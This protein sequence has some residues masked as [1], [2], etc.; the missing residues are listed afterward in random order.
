[1]FPGFFHLGF[2]Y[3]IMELCDLLWSQLP[4][5]LFDSENVLHPFLRQAG[6]LELLENPFLQFLDQLQ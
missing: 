1:M 4:V 5:L 3:V 6:V 2:V